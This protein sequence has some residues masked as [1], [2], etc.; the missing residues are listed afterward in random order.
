VKGEDYPAIIASG[1]SDEQSSKVQSPSVRGVLVQGL[2]ALDLSY[3]DSFEGDVSQRT[4]KDN[5]LT[6]SSSDWILHRSMSE[7]RS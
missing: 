7:R 3:L 2:T 1:S 5:L 4:L 6:R